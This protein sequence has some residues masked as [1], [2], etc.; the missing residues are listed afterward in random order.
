MTQPPN[1]HG[2]HEQS[3]R[4]AGEGE[5]IP[6]AQNHSNDA[7]AALRRGRCARR[8]RAALRDRLRDDAVHAERRE[9][10][11]DDVP[12]RE[13]ADEVIAGARAESRDAQLVR[14]PMH[15]SAVA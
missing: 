3:H 14:H 2:R 6:L 9:R 5:D 7:A 8:S 1:G 13:H 12:R 15:A 10:E 4:H 11:T